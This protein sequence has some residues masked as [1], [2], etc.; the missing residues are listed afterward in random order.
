[1]LAFTRN[2]WNIWLS[3]LTSVGFIV[4]MIFGT[5]RHFHK[6]LLSSIVEQIKPM[7]QAVQPNGGSSM[8]DGVNRIESELN[9]QGVELDSLTVRLEKHLSYHQGRE[10]ALA[11]K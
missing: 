11:E 2:D 4:G 6:K 3:I 10:S 9:R 5:Y 1:M 7:A 8:A